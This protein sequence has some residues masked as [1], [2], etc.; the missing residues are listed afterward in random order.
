MGG[1]R[2]GRYLWQ[3]TEGHFLRTQNIDLIAKHRGV[4]PIVPVHYKQGDTSVA[5]YVT[6]TQRFNLAL[7]FMLYAPHQGACG[8][9]LWSHEGIAGMQCGVWAAQIAVGITGDGDAANIPRMA[10]A[11]DAV[12]GAL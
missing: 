7:R 2:L 10:S 6:S 1:F 11:L 12:E 8:P 4:L 9:T 5:P 3:P